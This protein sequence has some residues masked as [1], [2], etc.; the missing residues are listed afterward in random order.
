[1]THIFQVDVAKKYGVEEAII[2]EH[3]GHWIKKNKANQVN[4]LHGYYWTYNSLSAYQKIFPYWSSRQIDRVLK[5][6]ENLGI[7]KT[8]HYSMNRGNRT[9]WYTII[10]KELMDSYDLTPSHQPVKSISPNRETIS[11]NREM[12]NTGIVTQVELPGFLIKK[13]K[14]EILNKY[15]SEI[16]QIIEIFGVEE[17]IS[18]VNTFLDN[19]PPEKRNYDRFFTVSYFEYKLGKK[20]PVTKAEKAR[21]IRDK[22]KK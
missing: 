7:I 14:K 13:I 10:D 2:I 20:E 19:F 6:L 21:V 8:G 12:Y 3:L 1:M 16:N 15:R 18:I 5:N 9:K 17:F 4:L 11:P 22:L